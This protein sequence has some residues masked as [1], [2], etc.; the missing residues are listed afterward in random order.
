MKENK[1][2]I[3]ARMEKN[4]KE[5]DDLHKTADPFVL[6]LQ[7][8][9]QKKLNNDSGNNTFKDSTNYSNNE[10]KRSSVVLNTSSNSNI[11]FGKYESTRELPRLTNLIR[12]KLRFRSLRNFD[13]YSQMGNNGTIPTLETKKEGVIQN[14]YII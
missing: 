3:D 7:Q 9:I 8:K 1:C 6:K 11:K 14:I 13:D 12:S 10:R 4:R 2:I 5:L